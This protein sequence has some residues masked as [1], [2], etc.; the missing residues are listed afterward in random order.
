MSPFSSQKQ[1]NIL[2]SYVFS[3]EG[4]SGQSDKKEIKQMEIIKE[5]NK[6]SENIVDKDAMKPKISKKN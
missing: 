3:R 1:N 2:K 5:L 6:P 4:S